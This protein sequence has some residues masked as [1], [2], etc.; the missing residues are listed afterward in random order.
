MRGAPG[1]LIAANAIEAETL[2]QFM[3]KEVMVTISVP[4]NLA[5]HRKYMA[6]IGTAFDLIET[7]YTKEAFRGI[8]TVGAGYC[9]FTEKDGR[10]IAIPKSVSFASMDDSEFERLYSDTITYILKE[11]P[12]A[13]AELNRIIDFV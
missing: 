12:L 8:C 13:D 6:L 4:R 2:R 10:L 3:G 7:E 11:W 1:G 9:T 5:F